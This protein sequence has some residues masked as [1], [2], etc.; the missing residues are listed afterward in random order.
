MLQR[1]P[2]YVVALPG[3]DAVAQWL[4]HRLPAMWTYRLVRAKNVLRSLFYYRLARRYPDQ[5][6]ERLVGLVR[7][8]LDGHSDVARHFTPSYKPW[9]QRVCVVPDGDMFRAIREGRASVVTDRI[10]RF[11]PQGIRLASGQELAAD[12]VVTATGLELNTLGDIAVRIDGRPLDPAQTL[13]YKGLMFSGVPNLAN[14]FGYTNASWTLK[15]DLTAGY[16][17]RLLNRMR[18]Q[19]TPIATPRHDPSVATQ[20]FLDFSSGYVL[21]AQD[22]L[23]R[24][25][26][27]R[28][29]RLYQN[30]LLDTLVLRW[31]R[32]DDG[33][34]VFGRAGTP[35]AA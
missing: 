21:R 31:G 34:M 20:P 5:T 8:Q 12:L 35:P 9:D 24:Q 23:P 11:V 27:T 17:C 7:Q 2:T 10:E 32:L 30:V 26:S 4:G 15:A 28:P 33:V 18:R 29:W 22:R 16:V 19:G 14:T 25:G 13:T 6:R 3:R 1:S